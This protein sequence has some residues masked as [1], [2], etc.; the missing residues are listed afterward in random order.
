MNYIKSNATP[1]VIGLVVGYMIA[2]KGGFG[3][4]TSKAKSAVHA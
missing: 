4:V 3:A 1:L 2:K